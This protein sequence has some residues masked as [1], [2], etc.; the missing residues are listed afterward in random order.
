M[1]PQ[2]SV[3]FKRENAH[4]ENIWNVAWGRRERVE[5]VVPVEDEEKEAGEE[6]KENEDGETNKENAGKCLKALGG[7]E[8][9]HSSEVA[10]LLLTQKP[11]LY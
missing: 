10:L 3:H 2:Y 1:S 4:D 7:L 9:L 5:E 8:G 6:N 11:I